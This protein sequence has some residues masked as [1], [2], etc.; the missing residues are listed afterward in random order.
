M[1]TIEPLLKRRLR[2]SALLGA[3]LIAGAGIGASMQQSE[4]DWVRHS[5]EVLRVEAE[6]RAAMLVRDSATLRY[7]Y[8]IPTFGTLAHDPDA[9]H[10]EA[11]SAYE[12]SERLRDQLLDLTADNPRQVA[13]LQAL[14]GAMARLR[15]RMDAVHESMAAGNPQA[16]REYVS[17]NGYLEDRMTARNILRDFE[18]E[19]YGLLDARQAALSRWALLLWAGL[20]ALVAMIATLLYRTKNAIGAEIGRA[21]AQQAQL[22]EL[23]FTD[24]E[25]GLANRRMLDE[26]FRR[27]A[28]LAARDGT[29]LS[30]VLLDCGGLSSVN[31]AWGH[32]AGA[33]I[34]RTVG[35]RIEAGAL[36]P[37]LI[38]RLHAT[39]LCV[40]LTG[41]D[42]ER[43]R[44]AAAAF[45]R[46]VGRAVSVI[47]GLDV[48]L[49][50]TTGSASY[51]LD[52]ASLDTLLDDALAQIAA[53]TRTPLPSAVP[54]GAARV[55]DLPRS[56]GGAR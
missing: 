36:R 43:A 28:E 33:R 16:A 14:G 19:E 37:D 26:R 54:H 7:A 1:H 41:V 27:L 4:S 30:L 42:G 50:I 34:L 56:A 44:T 10:N 40:L 22:R 38:A 5:Y 48:D 13:R 17:Q 39:Q 29:P 55:A 46:D 49:T 31:T 21:G 23:A 11:D 2:V 51:P 9:A 45:A 52:G 8:G 24:P 6:M 47:E 35:T 15:A 32:A 20:I 12:K 3:V 53:Q 25:T 18:T